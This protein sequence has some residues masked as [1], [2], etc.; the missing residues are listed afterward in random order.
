MK[1]YDNIMKKVPDYEYKRGIDYAKPNGPGYK[2]IKILYTIVLIFCFFINLL[3][4]LGTYMY[5]WN[6]D[7]GKSV[8]FKVLGFGIGLII[9]YVLTFFKK[10][11]IFNIS[12]FGLNV[13]SAVGLVLSVATPLAKVDGGYKPTFYWLHLIPL[14]LV[15][16]ISFFLTFIAVKAA[17]KKKASY[18]AIVLDIYNKYQESVNAGEASESDFEEVL[19]NYE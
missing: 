15:V 8:F 7:N 18:K 14:C 19:K 6:Y 3:V 1:Y 13:I 11:V 5:K 16:L 12:S 10:N 4:T 17:L 2:K 9:A